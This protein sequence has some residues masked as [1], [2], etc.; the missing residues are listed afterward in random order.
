MNHLLKELK[1]AIFSIKTYLFGLVFVVVG[2]VFVSIA[3]EFQDWMIGLYLILFIPL[4]IG[5]VSLYRE[6]NLMTYQ[7]KWLDIDLFYTGMGVILT[8]FIAKELS[9]NAVIASSA[10]GFIG[11]LVIKN[12]SVAIYC[13]SFAGMVS[14]FVFG[15]DEVILIAFVCG[16][17]YILLKPLFVGVGGKLG[18]IAFISTVGMAILLNKE[19]LMVSNE[20]DP[21]RLILVSVL[22][23]TIPFYLFDKLNLSQVLTSSLP[24]LIYAIILIYVIKQY[25]PCAIVFFS[26]SFIGMSS[27]SRLNHISWVILSGL[28]HAFLFYV[29]F[30]HYN[31]LGGKLG[32]MALTSVVIVV[33][34]KKMILVILQEKSY[35]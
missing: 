11:Y 32:L 9:I 6:M 20:I 21:I 22:G 28:V 14:S 7:I 35:D 5:F 29:Y 26:A 1:K 17:L 15:Y 19:T 12:H 2:Y 10:V 31:G 30:E 27:K 18:T 33:G 3:F 4:M 25:Q 13:G 8:Y 34:I 23:V 24:S 16:L